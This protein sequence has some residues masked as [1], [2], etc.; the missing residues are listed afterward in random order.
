MQKLESNLCHRCWTLTWISCWTSFGVIG[1]ENDFDSSCDM[2]QDFV[3]PQ[4]FPGLSLAFH[5]SFV[6]FFIFFSGPSKT[7]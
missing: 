2:L 4:S 5:F 7:K 3:N 6:A 1:L